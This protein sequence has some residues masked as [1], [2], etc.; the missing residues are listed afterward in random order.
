MDTGLFLVGT[1]LITAWVC[2]AEAI[3]PAVGLG[4]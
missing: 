3:Y 1:V 4:F 2:F